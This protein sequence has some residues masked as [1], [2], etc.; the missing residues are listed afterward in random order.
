[1][2]HVADIENDKL[3][4]VGENGRTWNTLCEFVEAWKVLDGLERTVAEKIDIT[5]L[6]KFAANQTY[7]VGCYRQFTDMDRLQ[8]AQR[9][10]LNSSAQ[11]T[12]QAMLDAEF[13]DAHH[14]QEV[15]HHCEQQ[16][17]LLIFYT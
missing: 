5:I 2:C 14:Q 17:C 11:P 9:R 8:R 7:H 15:G 10:L 13:L 16:M 12:S 4:S 1:M 3:S 6:H